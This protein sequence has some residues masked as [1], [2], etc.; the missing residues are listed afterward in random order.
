MQENS[1]S[2]PRLSLVLSFI[3]PVFMPRATQSRRERLAG[4]LG[5]PEQCHQAKSEQ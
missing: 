3:H 5:N 1:Q 2:E 4:T